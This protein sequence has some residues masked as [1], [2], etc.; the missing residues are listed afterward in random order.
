[1]LEA[2]RTA[3]RRSRSDVS[4]VLGSDD[5]GQSGSGCSSSPRLSVVRLAAVGVQAPRPIDYVPNASLGS[6]RCGGQ[7]TQQMAHRRDPFRKPQRPCRG[8]P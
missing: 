4:V 2:R 7:L 5:H 8:Q 3:P 1:V 6:Q